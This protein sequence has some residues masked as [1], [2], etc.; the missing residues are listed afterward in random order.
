MYDFLLYDVDVEDEDGSEVMTRI[1]FV[2][3]L[4]EQ[5]GRMVGEGG[6][7]EVGLAGEGADAGVV[8]QS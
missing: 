2:G 5:G 3:D 7:R 1:L 8:E 6:G 4:Q